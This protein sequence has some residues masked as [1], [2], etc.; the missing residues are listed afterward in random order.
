MSYLDIAKAGGGILSTVQETRS[1]TEDELFHKVSGLLD[2]IMQ[3]GVT[4]IECKSGYGLST[5]QE[6]KQ[7]SVYRRLA[8]EKP[9]TIAP[10][11]LGAHT[12][13]PEFSDNRKATIDLI[14][15]EMIPEVAAQ[16]LALFCNVF[17]EKSAFMIS[18]ARHILEAAKSVG[19]KP[20]VHADQLTSG[21]GADL[22]AVSADHLERVS[23]KGIRRM[24]EADVVAVSL[25]ISSLYT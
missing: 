16:K 19:S 24:Q 8:E 3:T 12:V 10:T 25:P 21:G 23:D 22:G 4:S 9:V 18:E 17:V 20:K 14:V 13:P 7:L 2:A 11:F 6:L 5:E 15:D 1:A